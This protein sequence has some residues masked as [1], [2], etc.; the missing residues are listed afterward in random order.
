MELFPITLPDGEEI[1]LEGLPPDASDELVLQAAT[2][3][4]RRDGLRNPI[5][6]SLAK[7]LPSGVRFYTNTYDEYVTEE[8]GLARQTYRVPADAT[9]TQRKQIQ[10]KRMEYDN[11][12]QPFL[13]RLAERSA[14]MEGY[15]PGSTLTPEELEE[16]NASI[17]EGFEEAQRSPTGNWERLGRN[18]KEGIIRDSDWAAFQSV[19]TFLP[20]DQE[21]RITRERLERMQREQDRRA[22][23]LGDVFPEPTFRDYPDEFLAESIEEARAAY[24][25]AQASVT[26]EQR[27]EFRRQRNE[28]LKEAAKDLGRYEG[29]PDSKG[30]L[31]T[32]AAGVGR[33]GAQF[34]S[35][36][37]LLAG[38]ATTARAPVSFAVRNIDEFLGAMRALRAPIVEGAKMN[39]ATVV[40][41]EPFVQLGNVAA[42]RQDDVDPL[43]AA[44][45]IGLGVL[46]GGAFEGLGRAISG[47]VD[48]PSDIL[49]RKADDLQRE[50][51]ASRIE[52]KKIADVK[53]RAEVERRLD[54]WEAQAERIV[55]E[56]EATGVRQQTEA[57]M[58]QAA[59]DVE[60][61]INAREV[62]RETA[63]LER[64]AAE[65]RARQSA[66]DAKILADADAEIEAGRRTLAEEAEDLAALRE[67]ATR[68]EAINRQEAEDL[69]ALEAS[70]GRAAARAES[71]GRLPSQMDVRE[72][73]R[74]R[75]T[76]AEP[77]VPDTRTREQMLR[78]ARRSGV[79]ATDLPPTLAQATRLA[80][81]AEARLA[82]R[83]D[84]LRADVS[85]EQRVLERL[86]T[87]GG[88][89]ILQTP[90]DLR[91]AIPAS[92]AGRNLEGGFISQAIAEPVAGALIGYQFG[93]TE[94]E[95]KQNALLGGGLGLGAGVLRG[96]I[97]DA[98]SRRASARN[99][100]V[101]M[102][103]AT[104]E[105][106][107]PSVKPDT[108]AYPTPLQAMEGNAPTQKPR[109]MPRQEPPIT[110][111]EEK[112]RFSERVKNDTETPPPVAAKLDATYNA[113]RN[114]E[115]MAV[116]D[117]RL[118]KQGAENETNRLLATKNPDVYDMA[119][120]LRLIDIWSAEKNFDMAAAVADH[121]SE[122]ASSYGQAIQILSLFRRTDPMD[123]E[124][125]AKAL[126]RRVSKQTGEVIEARDMKPREKAEYEK[127]VKRSQ[128][129]T[130]A[131]LK[132]TYD[133]RAAEIMRSLIPVDK[134]TKIRAFL[135]LAM[136]LNPK[137]QIRNV[138]GNSVAF[139]TY[140]LADVA[141][142][143]IDMA[144]SRVLPNG[145]RT[146]TYAAL[147]ERAKQT[148][149]ILFFDAVRGDFMRGYRGA[150][151]WNGSLSEAL[152][153]G[154][155]T[156]RIRSK[157]QSAG[158]IDFQDAKNSLRRAFSNPFMQALEDGLTI[159][160]GVGD[161]GFWQA[162]YEIS[163]RNQMSA[164]RLNGQ[165]LS[166][167]DGE[168]LIQAVHDA[169]RA[170]YMDENFF[171][172]KFNDLRKYL[173][174]GKSKSIGVGQV[175]M[176]F[177]QVPGS[178]LYKSLEF[179]P[180]GFFK[181]GWEMRPSVWRDGGP[182]NQKRLVDAL[183]NASGGT[184]GLFG[185][186][187]LMHRLGIISAAPDDD[188]DVEA[189]RKAMGWGG[190]R[191]NLSA[192]GRVLAAGPTKA[193]IEAG[194]MHAGDLVVN[195]DWAEPTAFAL[196]LGAQLSE[197]QEQLDRLGKRGSPKA[198]IS[199]LATSAGAGAKTLFEQPLL[200]GLT[201]F[202]GSV[203]DAARGR[204]PLTAPVA[205]LTSQALTQPI[206]TLVGQGQQM[207]D[208]RLPETRGGDPM[209][210]FT[211][212][213][214]AR[215]IAKVMG[216]TEALGIPAKRD[217]LGRVMERYQ[218]GGNGVFNVF[219]NP[220][221]AT[222]IKDDP[223]LGEAIRIYENTGRAEQMPRAVR[224]SVMING[225]SERLSGEQVAAY[226]QTLGVLT[227]RAMQ[228][229]I[230]T[231]R[232]QN[233][234]DETRA[235]MAANAIKV[236]NS[237]TTIALLGSRPGTIS[238]DVQDV[239][240]YMMQDDQLGALV[241]SQPVNN[242]GAA[243]RI[244][245]Y[246]NVLGNQ[247]DPKTRETWLAAQVKNGFITRDEAQSVANSY[248]ARVREGRRGEAMGAEQPE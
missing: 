227:D 157:L 132:L 246:A 240:K 101:E 96:R 63:L 49:I 168:M 190:Y 110:G 38:A 192:F 109:V 197:E 226:Q 42:A 103:K 120:A 169:N 152:S 214:L 145:K 51:D 241:R 179:S 135:N 198:Q 125:L 183:A 44:T 68:G 166:A 204:A 207:M 83:P 40:A 11:Y 137:T 170:I 71:G 213:A 242:L 236:L 8:G 58:Q 115:V 127:M 245:F 235:T 65:L 217:V 3:L 97:S 209:E 93:E 237:A 138:L 208:N 216:V 95:R 20:E 33:L 77:E 10:K 116:V 243:E 30:V 75:T 43:Q 15:S 26:P 158:K 238:R 134:A 230:T 100:P 130:D 32:V 148:K 60:T 143:I 153:E 234:D 144:A 133:A 78:D 185:V 228:G 215:P 81:A 232:Y 131:E 195:Y 19:S 14:S 17:R 2:A 175:I 164:A 99:N 229:M 74:G 86:P 149:N 25:R 165:S 156:V 231:E 244:E 167:P 59:R 124:Q 199:A 55:A 66:D 211:K 4:M 210:S 45:N 92:L 128:E 46:A 41:S 181:A 172:K 150:E 48:L 85:A 52:A 247:K 171:S 27:Q 94:E 118:A 111:K 84:P 91:G 162:Q 6:V 53:Q 35:P 219:F 61:D 151:S 142:P 184:V 9:E 206:P 28:R 69:A 186:G 57:E 106:P 47:L 218:N 187:Y 189:A 177:S 1:D 155:Q 178:L 140:G 188:Y 112:S 224:A 126:A 159:A 89:P 225:V 37:N 36:T 146:R 154:L 205:T 212:M 173:N 13:Q 200:Q 107:P 98:L 88:V 22:G 203:I 31:E 79:P 5:D 117:A 90:R 24:Q 147:A 196:A 113:V 248:M 239:V 182:G 161:R 76:L 174:F 73:P 104:A 39:A 191:M 202:V 119:T 233:A 7:R 50:L 123:A 34:T 163:L 129:T 102:A 87:E 72:A 121:M 114:P 122:V 180:F 222:R 54:E 193:A 201:N 67:S 141:A 80:D 221:F 194:K 160:L 223:V 23:K 220:A 70:A 136:L 82:A 108:A 16:I 21:S 29:I 56:R 18:F 105:L 176:P 12:A 64:Q 62:A 139:V